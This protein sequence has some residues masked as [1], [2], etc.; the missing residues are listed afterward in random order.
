MNKEE[1]LSEQHSSPAPA[2]FSAAAITSAF[3]LI[4]LFIMYGETATLLNAGR[5]PASTY[6]NSTM[7]TT[8]SPC[9]MCTGAI[10]LYKIR[11]VVIGE[12]S[13][14]KA[15]GED[16]LRQRGVEVVVMD[17]QECRTLMERFVRESP[18]VWWEDI[19]VVGEEKR[20]EGR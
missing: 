16:Y 7:Y 15:A 1:F 3:S 11:R 17:D 14:F 5:L 13:T 20:E 19:G 18:G 10:L 9:D 4:H 2:S 6:A 8:L 12:N